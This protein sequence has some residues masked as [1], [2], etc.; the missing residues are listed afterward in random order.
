MKSCPYCGK[1][2]SNDLT[3]CPADGSQLAVAQNLKKDADT[4]QGSVFWWFLNVLGRVVGVFFI[5]LGAGFAFWGL[6][7]ILN[8]KSTIAVNGKPSGDLWLKCLPLIAGV[9]AGLLGFLILVS[10]RFR[11]NL[12]DKP[13]LYTVEKKLPLSPKPASED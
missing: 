8:P 5:I 2:Y 10:R 9:V 12:G 1:E 7:L 4:E 13:S 3:I 11:P 6:S